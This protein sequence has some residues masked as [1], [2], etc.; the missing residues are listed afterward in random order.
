MTIINPNKHKHEHHNSIMKKTSIKMNSTGELWT[1]KAC[2][3]NS[4]NIKINSTAKANKLTAQQYHK[5]PKH[6]MKKATQHE[7]E[8]EH[9]I[10]SWTSQL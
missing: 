2:K 6:E 9:N 3:L 4:T 5:Q 10:E 7:Q 1:A 8:N